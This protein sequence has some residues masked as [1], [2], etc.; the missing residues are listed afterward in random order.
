MSDV[1]DKLHSELINEETGGSNHF[2]R[3]IGTSDKQK[4]EISDTTNQNATLD[5]AQETETI[6]VHPDDKS[7][8][9]D[10][11]T[12][13]EEVGQGYDEMN[14]EPE[15]KGNEGDNI[16]NRMTIVEFIELDENGE[17][18]VVKRN[19]P[20]LHNGEEVEE[21]AE[22]MEE[23]YFEVIT[24]TVKVLTK[25]EAGEDV[26]KE[27]EILEEVMLDGLPKGARIV[28]SDNPARSSALTHPVSPRL[29]RQLDK[30]DM[31][32]PAPP[33]D[34]SDAEDME[35][36]TSM[37]TSVDAPA[38]VL[39]VGQGVGALPPRNGP[40]VVVST[41]GSL[42]QMHRDVHFRAHSRHRKTKTGSGQGGIRCPQSTVPPIP[43][44]PQLRNQLP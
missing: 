4:A 33:T 39:G 13:N 34:I 14:D 3:P 26:E 23:S 16:K 44:R 2:E 36:L 7:T 10:A 25:N 12:E 21:E 19:V 28:R 35:C 15:V 9:I 31:D 8:L 29:R 22:I 41:R 38:T 37:Q 18:I 30:R 20:F 43:E 17:E 5:T 27:V 1:P 6:N 40:T 11:E 42:A 32:P 24:K